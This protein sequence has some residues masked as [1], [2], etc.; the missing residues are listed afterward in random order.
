MSWSSCFRM[1]SMAP[2]GAGLPYSRP[3]T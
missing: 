1:A 2:R 3:L